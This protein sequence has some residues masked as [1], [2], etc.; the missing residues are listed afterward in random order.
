MKKKP[1]ASLTIAAYLFCYIFDHGTLAFALPG[2]SATSSGIAAGQLGQIAESAGPV[3]AFQADLFTGRAQTSVP[4]FVP[5]GRKN[6]QPSLALS[7]SSS[8]G[9]SWLGAGWGLDLGFIQRDLK[10]GVPKYDATDKYVFS[11][12]GVYSELVSVGTNEYRAKDE[13]LFLKF[14][15]DAA[16]NKWTVTD[17][18]GTKY[19][20]G[21]AAASR[22]T[23]TLGT[24]KWALD[25][26]IDTSGNYMSVTYT[27]DQGELYPAQIDYNG[28]ETQ[29]FA[30]SHR[31]IFTLEN[32]N[33]ST[34]SYMTGA[35]VTTAKR[36]KTLEVKVKD[37]AGVYQLARKYTLGYEYSAATA[38]SRLASVTEY[39]TD[40]TTSLP[41]TTFTYQNKDQSFNSMSDFSGIQRAASGSEDYDYVRTVTSAAETKVDLVDMNGD[42]FNDRVQ[43]VAGNT[44]W[45]IQLNNGTGFGSLADFG[46]LYKPTSWSGYDWISRVT[47]AKEQ[48]T[49]LSDINGDGL[50]DRIIS[51]DGNTNWV[52]QLNTGSALS[53]TNTNWGTI[54]R[55]VSSSVRYDHIRY[56]PILGSSGSLTLVELFDINGDGLPDRVMASEGDSSWKV[57]LNTGSGFAAMQ[58]WGTTER[59]SA[60]SHRDAIRAV[61]ETRE[62]FV[63]MI[64]LNGD[65]LPDRV[66]A[67]D[68]NTNWKVQWNTGK[69][70]TTMQDYGPILRM[71][72]S[73]RRDFIR[74]YSDSGEQ[75]TDLFDVNGDGLPDRVQA[76]DGNSVWKVQYNTGTGFTSLQDFGTI[77]FMSSSVRYSYPRWVDSG[78][79]QGPR[80]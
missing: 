80:I 37:G 40:G 9:N 56:S 28:N 44:S 72:S 1:I 26:T 47:D 22:Q 67:M 71:D 12:Q 62:S 48:V 29:S 65:G 46:T 45:K 23:N 31:V 58:N 60:I 41:A 66:Q 57:Q 33:D 55:K 6:I 50:P 17:K 53:G 51:Q 14:S 61:S 15:F 27:T 70:F 49:D 74:Y 3:K 59:M 39:G 79:A 30:H 24:F 19:C 7:Y 38:R 43:A 21:F 11:F 32:R 54:S 5:P 13:A 2:S 77:G 20:F 25:K 76:T 8:G 69:G 18:S 35:K 63:D 68:G 78:G 34:F 42:G 73:V 75:H 52:V 4:I 16:N 10:N 64:D 36:L